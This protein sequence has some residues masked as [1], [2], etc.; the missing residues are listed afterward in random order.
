M[1]K[2]LIVI[3]LFSIFKGRNVRRSH[4]GKRFED[5]I[6]LAFLRRLGTHTCTGAKEVPNA[7]TL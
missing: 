6:P 2:Q 1:H 3:D 4:I 5:L 7:K